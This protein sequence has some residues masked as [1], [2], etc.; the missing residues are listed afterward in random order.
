MKRFVAWDS[1][2]RLSFAVPFADMKPVIYLDPFL[3]HISELALSTSDRQTKV[4]ACELLHSLV[5]F[6]VGKSAQMVEGDDSLPP[7]YKLHKRLFPVLLR[8]ACDVDQVCALV[9]IQTGKDVFW[10]SLRGKTLGLFGMIVFRV[11]FRVWVGARYEL[12]MS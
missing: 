12:C 2:K 10:L 6:M 11:D 4:A 1:E 9:A 5:I 3:P 8:L 7:M